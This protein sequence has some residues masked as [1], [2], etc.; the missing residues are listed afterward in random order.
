MTG[1]IIFKKSKVVLE[2][3][4][5]NLKYVYFYVLLGRYSPK[6]TEK[7]ITK[8]KKKEENRN[9]GAETLG[10]DPP[11]WVRS[12]PDRHSYQER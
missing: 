9:G 2:D 3:N 1:C 11:A 7:G 8:R 6:D 10:G 12:P 5:K 4:E